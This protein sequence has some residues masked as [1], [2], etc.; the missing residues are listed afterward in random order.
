MN[1]VDEK[2]F[3]LPRNSLIFNFELFLPGNTSQDYPNGPLEGLGKFGCKWAY[4]D[5]TNQVVASNTTFSWWIYPCKKSRIL[6]HCFQRYWW[7]TN[8]GIWLDDSISPI[9]CEQEFSQVWGVYRKTKLKCLS[10]LATSSKK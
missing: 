7:P 10:F 3:D 5:T 4:Q 6:M 8:S 2:C 9:T 1:Q